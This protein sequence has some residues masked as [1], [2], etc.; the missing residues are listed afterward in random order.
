M[1]KIILGSLSLILIGLGLSACSS[2]EA[3]SKTD[4]KIVT[5]YLSGDK[6]EGNAY[7]KMAKKYE[8]ETG[9]I[10]KI[11]DVPYSDL[12]TKI[13]KAVQAK[14]EPDI[15]RV[16]GV[17]ST[18]RNS[19]QDLSTIAKK[20]KTNT[21]L[22][23][24]D[25][26]TK[27]VT[28]IPSDLTSNALFINKTLFDKADVDY[29]TSEKNTW[30]WNEFIKSVKQVQNKADARY[31]LVVDPSDQRL[32]TITY[33]FGGQDFQLNKAGTAYKTDDAT[34]QALSS[35]VDWN[36]NK[37]MPKTVWTSGEDPSAMFK[38]G[39]VAAYLSGSWQ[40]KDFTT[41]IKSFDWATTYMPYQKNRD[42]NLGGNY[43]LAF[44]NGHNPKG[45]QAF[46]KWLYQPKN[47]QQLC[48]YAGYL[49]AVEN[50]SINYGKNKDD[51]KIIQNEIKSASDMA[52]YQ[53][54][55]GVKATMAG[56]KGLSG[57]YKD[58]IANVINGQESL[59]SAIKKIEKDYNDGFLTTE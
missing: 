56:H 28:A 46:L 12:T 27:E 31:G 55:Q 42:T 49:P 21:D 35:F 58:S 25:E 3:Q 13:D 16:S 53:T 6:S 33:Q 14:D 2:R 7:T 40:I 59:K 15:A 8:K 5:F 10:V 29:P 30:T 26:K 9:I 11:T 22:T 34:V 19:L 32:R 38:S 4:D 47:Y 39:Q 37:L 43:L 1:K 20:V 57:A 18:W 44:K 36:D 50:M 51:Y 48:E 54:Q 17:G 52:G 24:I 45:G 23:I 41:N